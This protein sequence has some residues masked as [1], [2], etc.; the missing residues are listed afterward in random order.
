[1]IYAKTKERA[2]N[3]LY[4]LLNPDIKGDIH[5]EKVDVE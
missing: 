3:D 2:I 4:Q 1:M 5:A